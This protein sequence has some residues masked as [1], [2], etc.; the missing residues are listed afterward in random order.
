MTEIIVIGTENSFLAI[1]LLP[2][3]LL[4]CRL[5]LIHCLPTFSYANE[6]FIVGKC[7]SWNVFS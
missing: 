6:A 7:F 1:I 5:Y 4:N 3:K 2:L